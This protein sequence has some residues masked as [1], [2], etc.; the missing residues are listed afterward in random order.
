MSVIGRNHY[1][2]TCALLLAAKKRRLD[3]ENAVKPKPLANDSSVVSSSH[4]VNLLRFG[5]ARMSLFENDQYT[6][7]ETYFVLFEEQN[8]PTGDQLRAALEELGPRYQIENVISAENGLCESLTLL[9][10]DDYAA[11]DITYVAGNEVAEQLEE[12]IKQVASSALVEDPVATKE[13]LMR[14]NARFDL[15][16]FEQIVYESLDDDAEE[17]LDPGALLVVLEQLADLCKG[18]GFDPASGTV[19]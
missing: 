14:C 9:S 4:F 16:H 1:I 11:M 3:S 12:A 15:F 19:M 10:P 2:F 6:W 7:R 5:A 13:R 17:F 8:R 18:V